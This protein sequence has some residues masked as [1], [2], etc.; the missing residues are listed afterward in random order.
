MSIYGCNDKSL[1]VSL[2][3]CPFSK[4]IIAGSSLGPMTCPAT[5]SWPDNGVRLKS[6]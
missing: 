3:L 5:G 6:N 2:I 1:E 4:I